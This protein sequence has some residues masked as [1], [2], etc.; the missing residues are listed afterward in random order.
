MHLILIASSAPPGKLSIQEVAEQT[1]LQTK[2]Y[3]ELQVLLNKFK[4]ND[5]KQKERVGSVNHLRT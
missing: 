3:L 4:I 1:G 2:V 5:D